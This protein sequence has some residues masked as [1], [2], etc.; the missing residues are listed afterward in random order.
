LCIFIRSCA[1]AQQTPSRRDKPADVHGIDVRWE[2][3]DNPLADIKEL[4]NSAFDTKSPLALTFEE[5][6][7][8]KRIYLTGHWEIEQED[9]KGDLGNI[10]S[11]IMP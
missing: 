8:G 2:F 9:V 7:R 5:H 1:E 11:A 3:L 6:D 10:M 4:G